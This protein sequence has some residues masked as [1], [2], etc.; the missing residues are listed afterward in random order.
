[1]FNDNYFKQIY[2]IDFGLAK[3]VR[4]TKRNGRDIIGTENFC[5]INVMNGIEYSYRDDL[6][7]IGYIML[8][9]LHDNLKW[10]D[11]TTCEIREAKQL[12]NILEMCENNIWLKKY[13]SHCYGLSFNK[14]P[15]YS[16]IN[17]LLT[18]SVKYIFNT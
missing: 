8:Y 13:F 9:L 14:K 1:M 6:I 16:F 2:I 12:K 3:K 17:H 7:S 11:Q 4:D 5:S 18:D 10:E 15:S